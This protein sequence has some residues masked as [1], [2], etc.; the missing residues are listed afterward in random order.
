MKIRVWLPDKYG[1]TGLYRLDMPHR[2]L[3]FDVEFSTDPA[4]DAD[5]L[6][7]SKANLLDVLPI[8]PDIKARGTIF[9]LDYDDYWILPPNHL[10]YNHYREKG[11]TEILREGLRIA[12]HVTCTTDLLADAIRPINK[13][14]TV[15]ENAI[16]YSR[17]Q[18]QI[19]KLQSDKIRFGWVGGHCHLPDILLLDGTPARLSGEFFI[20]LFGHDLQRNSIYDRFAYIMSGHNKV[21]NFGIVKQRPVDQYTDFYNYFDVALIPL[22]DDKFNSMKSELKLAEA[23]CFKKA[24]IVSDVYPYRP[25][26][27]DGKNCLTTTNKTDWYKKMMKLIK[28]P[29]MADDLGNQLYEDLHDYFDINRVNE[30]RI[31]LYNLLLTS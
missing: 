20:L 16:D 10:L 24:A 28:N 6:V 23:A 2:N 25:Y 12:D 17:P 29:A 18:F 8:V 13:N 5:I 26:I 15:L 11:I 4:V 14:V 7:A 30:K 22:R 9:V 31:E 19:N 1:G 3:P 27:R 21:K